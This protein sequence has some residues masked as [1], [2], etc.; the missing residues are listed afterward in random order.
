MKKRL[1]PILLALTLTLPLP[2]LAKEASTVF[3]DV[4]PEDWFAPY[5]EVCVKDGLL[6]GVGDG[7]FAPGQTLNGDE[8]LVMAARVLLMANG[9]TE[10]PKGPDAQGFW[11]WAGWN[12]GQYFPFGNSV[13]ET[14]WYVDSWCWDPLIY[15]AQAGGPDLFP[16]SGITYSTDRQTFFKAL[17]FAAQGLELPA[18]NEVDAVPGTRDEAILGLYRAGIL[19][20]TDLY[21]SFDGQ[22]PLTRAEAA[23]ALARLARPELR[24]EFALQE[25]PYQNYTLTYLMDGESN[26]GLNYPLL[27][28]SGSTESDPSGL[29]SLDGTLHPWPGTTPSW[30]LERSGDYAWFSCWNEETEDDPYDQ[31]QGLM[32]KNGEMVVPLGAYAMVR[33]TQDGHFLVSDDE[34]G[35]SDAPWRLLNHDL[36][37]AAQLPAPASVLPEGAALSF[38]GPGWLDLNQGVMAYWDEESGLWGYVGM[39]GKWVVKPTWVSASNFQRGYAV[40]EN[41]SGLWGCIDLAGNVVLPFQYSFLTPS[42][43]SFDYDGPMVFAFREQDGRTG[44]LPLGGESV[45]LPIEEEH[46]HISTFQNG[47]GLCYSGYDHT[48]CWYIDPSGAPISEKFDWAGAI[49]AD[50]QGFVGI[51]GK[52]YRIEFE[53]P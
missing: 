40:V 23:A 48:Y 34:H 27:A 43:D 50:G 37:V 44:L 5:V 19:A 26:A 52:I 32:D 28:I 20:G 21:G 35:S 6:N 11:D 22:A 8:A 16:D 30:G 25:S 15:L 38:S 3:T 17:A 13:A 24:V 4:S 7:V 41:E 46:K 42:R 1:L 45:Y 9:E 18:I 31:L 39:D 51:E 14:Q 53:T 29:L 49:N 33:A 2:A 10:F 36:T 12:K 47:Y